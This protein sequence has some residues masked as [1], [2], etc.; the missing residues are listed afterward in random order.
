MA[1]QYLD[2]PTHL[3]FEQH[4]AGL[5]EAT[6]MMSRYSTAAGLDVD[7]PPCPE[8]TVRALI[9]H[10]G[11]IHRWARGLLRGEKVDVVA[12][13]KSGR[14]NAHPV[15]WLN[16]GAISLVTTLVET[17]ENADVPVILHDPP[18][19]RLFW[20]RRM[21]HE[22]TMHGI[23]ALAAS[24]RRLPRAEETWIGVDTALDGIDELLMGFVPR[25]K[26][27]LRSTTPVTIAVHT[28]DAEY[29]WTVRVSDEAPVVVRHEDAAGQ[30]QADLLIEAPAV[31]LYLALWHRT[32]EVAADGLGPWEQMTV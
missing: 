10:T 3:T 8:W 20:A 11:A 9:G 14:R 4:L 6:L 12:T 13:A 23:D 24:L 22:T 29:S 5:H 18:P 16:D 7:V 32:D 30:G 15:D 26:S 27:Q 19:P 31:A 21:H 28:P 25:S 2:V 1:C 17:P